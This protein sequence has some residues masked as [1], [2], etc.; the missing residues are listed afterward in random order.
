MCVC[1]APHLFLSVDLL[2]LLATGS[3][4]LVQL[5]LR[6]SPGRGRL[7]RLLFELREARRGRI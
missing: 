2:V 6:L 7:E 5:R 1:I 3:A 4:H